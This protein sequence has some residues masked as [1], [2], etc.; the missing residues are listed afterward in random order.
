MPAERPGSAAVLVP[1][2]LYPLFGVVLPGRDIGAV[3]VLY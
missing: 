1:G 3:V 2:L